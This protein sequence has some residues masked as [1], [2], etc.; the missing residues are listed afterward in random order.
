V[1]GA[2][3]GCATGVRLE[4]GAYVVRSKG[5]R[6]TA[7]AGWERIESEA[8]LAIRQSRLRAALMAHATCEGQTPRRPLAVL[9][10]HLRFG[11]RDVRDLEE[12]PVELGGQRGV[13]SR[14]VATLDGVPVAV[15]AVTL[16][17]RRCV[18]DLVAVAPAGHL[19]AVAD[20]FARFT[21]SF[22]LTGDG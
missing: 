8:D 13:A 3:V 20:D 9:A 11:L 18:Y 14:F 7:L 1:I 17:G 12:S 22:T 6:V 10:R 5:Y 4:G 19:D 2:L 21:G 16:H 15:S